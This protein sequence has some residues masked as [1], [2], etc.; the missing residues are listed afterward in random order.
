MSSTI[1]IFSYL[2]HTIATLQSK[3]NRVG[4]PEEIQNT[5]LEILTHSISHACECALATAEEAL[6][7]AEE[8]VTFALEDRKKICHRL[9]YDI[10]NEM[11]T[12]NALVD[13]TSMDLLAQN[14]YLLEQ[15]TNDLSLLR[16]RVDVRELLRRKQANLLNGENSD[17]KNEDDDDD[18]D[19]VVITFDSILELARDVTRRQ[20]DAE[21]NAD[22]MTRVLWEKIHSSWEELKVSASERR[23]FE[24]KVQRSTHQLSKECASSP[25]LLLP[26]WA[27]EVEI[28]RDALAEHSYE[29]VIAQLRGEVVAL[30]TEVIARIE[31]Q[32]KECREFFSALCEEYF[33]L[34][35]DPEYA[36]QREPSSSR[37]NHENDD[38]SGA[39]LT[40]ALIEG[41]VLAVEH[42]LKVCKD[43]FALL[44]QRREL[45]VQRDSVE[46]TAEQRREML[47]SKRV[48]MAQHLLSEERVRKTLKRE[49]PK[50]AQKLKGCALEYRALV[51]QK[52]ALHVFFD[53][54]LI[55]IEDEVRAM[56]EDGGTDNTTTNN[57][58]NAATPAHRDPT[59]SSSN[60]RTPVRNSSR[61]RVSALP[62]RVTIPQQPISTMN[63]NH[64]HKK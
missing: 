16:E 57:N 55:N 43:A 27:Q 37:I 22:V 36:N 58:N 34:S 10:K 42:R 33:S 39:T 62:T 61:P 32:V 20:A 56:I 38:I 7:D 35:R 64:Y 23:A 25:A 30:N 40:L 49:L 48:N 8:K 26:K 5:Q 14:Q 18:D 13:A 60:T 59:S 44:E 50:V 21:R 1:T 41:E 11:Q 52:R 63:N 17:N 29:A 4:L 19:D 15:N 6:I 9:G 12:F 53:G 3:W 31:L 28:I 45:Y 51:H 2:S 54:T 24:E 46:L 47:T